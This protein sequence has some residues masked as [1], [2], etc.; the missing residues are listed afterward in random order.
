MTEFCSITVM[1][2]FV[3]EVLC[4]CVGQTVRVLQQCLG[5]PRHLCSFGVPLPLSEVMFESLGLGSVR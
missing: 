4:D 3:F 1:T 2:H 5:G